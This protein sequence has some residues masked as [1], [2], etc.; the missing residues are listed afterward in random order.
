[1]AVSVVEAIG[2]QTSANP[3]SLSATFSGAPIAGDVALVFVTF[4][5]T[6]TSSSDVTLS[7]LSATWRLISEYN[8]SN[9]GQ[10]LGIYE[11]TG[12]TGASSTVTVTES[13]AGAITRFG[14]SA[15]LLRGTA[16]LSPFYNIAT[17]Y[18]NSNPPIISHTPLVAGDVVLGMFLQANTTAPTIATSPASGWTAGTQAVNGTSFQWRYIVAASTA[19]HTMDSNVSAFYVSLGVASQAGAAQ[20]GS[21]LAETMTVDAA[22]ERRV[23]AMSLDAMTALIVERRVARLTADVIVSDPSRIL[24]STHMEVMVKR[25]LFIGWGVPI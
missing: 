15:F 13:Y 2:A 20:V 1:M 21:A 7:G 5:D 17:G 24:A 19:A 12:L 18:H 6:I 16:G 23:A 10:W 4:D 8:V 9:T 14:L 22:L 11:A 3:G 25:R